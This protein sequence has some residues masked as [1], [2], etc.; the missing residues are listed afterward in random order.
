MNARPSHDSLN[1]AIVDGIARHFLNPE[2][3]ARDNAVAN[4][5]YRKPAFWH[6]AS[7][8]HAQIAELSSEANRFASLERALDNIEDHYSC[9]GQHN[10]RIRT[11]EI[12]DA[13]IPLNAA[14]I[15][16]LDEAYRGVGTFRDRDELED[17][18]ALINAD[19]V[20]AFVAKVA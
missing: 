2:T 16:E 20:A 8:T 7:A 1:T 19:R 14:A 4:L 3:A 18:G 5:R 11:A 15:R 17:R 9:T 13:L 12:F 6:T 10:R